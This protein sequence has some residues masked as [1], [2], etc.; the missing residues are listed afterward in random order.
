MNTDEIL[1]SYSEY[2][3]ESEKSPATVAEYLRNVRRLLA[4]LGNRPLEKSAV[5]GFKNSL[6][7]S[8][9]YSAGSINTVIA[10]VNSYLGYLD[11]PP[12]L[13][14]GSMRTEKSPFINFS[15]PSTI[16]RTGRSTIS[17]R[18]TVSITVQRKLK[19]ITFA[20][21]S[22]AAARIFSSV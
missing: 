17:L 14:N 7:S 16:R 8:G 21:V 1:K 15:A 22:A 4:Y 12:M 20:K 5:L 3:S 18:R 6:V 11:S 2:L 13:R 10:S 19:K 9:E